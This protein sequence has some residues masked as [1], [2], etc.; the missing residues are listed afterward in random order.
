MKPSACLTRSLSCQELVQAGQLLLAAAKAVHQLPLQLGVDLELAQ[1]FA[2]AGLEAMHQG[3]G[4]SQPQEE[5]DDHGEQGQ[6][7]Q[8]NQDQKQGG[9]VHA[10]LGLRHR[11]G[12]QKSGARGVSRDGCARNLPWGGEAKAKSSR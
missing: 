10:Y 5:D 6:F 9:S 2:L 12:C 7:G 8:G 3:F 4:F 11:R 1:E